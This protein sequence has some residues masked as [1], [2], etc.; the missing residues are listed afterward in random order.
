MHS[1]LLII[2]IPLL[3]QYQVFSSPV[4]LWSNKDLPQSAV[5]LS[6]YSS[7]DFISNSICKIDSKQIQVHLIVV[8]QLTNQDIQRGLQRK[9]PVLL[10][11]KNEKS[12]FRYFPN[13]ADDV[14]D[15]LSKLPRSNNM[16]CSHIHFQ[17]A[18]L[19]IYETLKEALDA[20]Q[21]PVD[22]IGTN[23]N[24]V[25]VKALVGTPVV[26]QSLSRR[27]R[28][29]DITEDNVLVSENR[30]CMFYANELF[31]EEPNERDPSAGNYT[32][33]LDRSSCTTDEIVTSNG[34]MTSV[35]L[36][37]Y[38]DN[39]MN[40]TIPMTLIANITERYWY[41]DT[42]TMN[43]SEYR[44]FAY[45][46]HSQMETPSTYSYVCKTA[47]FVKYDSAGHGLYD[48]KNKFFLTNI[49]FQPFNADG[50]KFGLPNYCTSF[51][52]SGIWMG[53][54]STLLCLGIL[55]FGIYRMMSI[56]SNDRFDDPKGKP[57]IIKAQ[58]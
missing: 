49:Q 20:M 22:S 1:L 40:D 11:A 52:T 7:I 39:G 2:I 19:K 53:L 43:G 9:H 5:P 3:S 47:V 30:T 41:L 28:D 27:R 44:Y 38:W 58:E 34:N 25:I 55:L 31:W 51:F 54:T 6:R 56:K 16:H 57:L 35:I 36:D 29:I 13:V 18:S 50:I 14:Y 23:S 24:M 45:G 12:Q 46:M 4:L 8:D 32:L 17:I 42:V 33:D 21:S 15:T 48:F 37:L 10:D 26:D